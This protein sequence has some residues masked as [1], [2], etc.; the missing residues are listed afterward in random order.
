MLPRH[1]LAAAALV[2]SWTMELID[3]RDEEIELAVATLKEIAG[4]G[5]TLPAPAGTG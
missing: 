3:Y 2:V 5:A 1:V 4:R